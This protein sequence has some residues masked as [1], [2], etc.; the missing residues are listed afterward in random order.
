MRGTFCWLLFTSALTS[1]DGYGGGEDSPNAHIEQTVQTARY[2]WLWLWD[3]ILDKSVILRKLSMF[4]VKLT[5][6]QFD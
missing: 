1:D 6:C 2:V 3:I 4:E 5:K